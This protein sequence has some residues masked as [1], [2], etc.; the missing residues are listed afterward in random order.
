MKLYNKKFNGFQIYLF[1]IFFD[2]FLNFD[3]DWLFREEFV[4]LLFVIL[5]GD[6]CEVRWGCGLGVNNEFVGV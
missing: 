2:F 6:V 5:E 4:S 1:L 3:V